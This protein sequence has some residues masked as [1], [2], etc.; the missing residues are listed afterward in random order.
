MS[1]QLKR[2]ED[3]LDNHTDRLGKIE[4][5]LDTYN[6]LLDIHIEATN[7]NKAEIKDLQKFRWMALGMV[8]VITFLT[9][10][11]IKLI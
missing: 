9:Q 4:G 7:Q 8:A 5:R 11:L 2:I 10:I 6:A 3:K 1:D